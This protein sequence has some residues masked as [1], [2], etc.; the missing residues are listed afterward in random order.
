MKTVILD[1][2]RIST[3]ADVHDLFSKELEFPQFYGRNLDALYDCLTDVG[4]EAEIK[5]RNFEKLQYELGKYADIIIRVLK[6]ASEVNS[7]LKIKV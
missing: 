6:D 4:D 1:G 3:M 2:E 7:K 5:I